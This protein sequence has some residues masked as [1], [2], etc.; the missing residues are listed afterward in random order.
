MNEIESDFDGTSHG[1]S[2]KEWPGSRV[3]PAIIQNCVGGYH[4]TFG[5]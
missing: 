4:E 1:D 3:R 2:C 5:Y